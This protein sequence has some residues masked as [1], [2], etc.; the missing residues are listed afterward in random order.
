MAV[1]LPSAQGDEKYT[2][3]IINSKIE[4]LVI[5]DGNVVNNFCRCLQYPE[6]STVSGSGVLSGVGQRGNV[7]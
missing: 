4:T 5:G 2:I 3:N 7:L 1:S 6:H